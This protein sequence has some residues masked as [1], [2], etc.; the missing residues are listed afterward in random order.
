MNYKNGDIV[1]IKRDITEQELKSD[2]SWCMSDRYREN[3]QERYIVTDS[4]S[5]EK[6]RSNDV[7]KV[8]PFEWDPS[9][10]LS[11]K[12]DGNFYVSAS[13][14]EPASRVVISDEEYLNLM[15]GTD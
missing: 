5:T 6:W 8:A 1:I 7:I 15:L 4:T 14:L 2:M 10:L 11:S 3:P 9:N 13:A 12:W